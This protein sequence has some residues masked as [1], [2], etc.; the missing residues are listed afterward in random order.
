M[1]HVPQSRAVAWLPHTLQH[2]RG[3]GGRVVGWPPAKT[4]SIQLGST[5]ACLYKPK[6]TH[7]YTHTHTRAKTR[8]RKLFY[9]T[10]DSTSN[11]LLP[12]P[13]PSKGCL[14]LGGMWLQLL[15]LQVC[16]SRLLPSLF[17]SSIPLGSLFLFSLHPPLP[18]PL[19][20]HL[21]N[22]LV[23][24]LCSAQVCRMGGR[25]GTPVCTLNKACSLRQPPCE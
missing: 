18:I 14:S 16:W 4:P 9:F 13:V 20:T 17:F 21:V 3:L 2:Q 1:G 6:H 11:P 19:P 8:N 22:L 25:E 10:V 12:R 24:S 5:L 7:T 15:L 23:R